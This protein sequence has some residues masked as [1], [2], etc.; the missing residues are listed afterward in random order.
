MGRNEPRNLSRTFS[1]RTMDCM[2][3][4][5]NA[6]SISLHL[7]LTEDRVDGLDDV[8]LVFE[9]PVPIRVPQAFCPSRV[10]RDTFAG[11]V[12]GDD[13]VLV[14]GVEVK[15]GRISLLDLGAAGAV[16]VGKGQPFLDITRSL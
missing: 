10:I 13:R 2:R 16:D 11:Q 7:R 9:I 4:L 1:G 15:L 6:S 5:W 12:F 14:R 8:L 3:C